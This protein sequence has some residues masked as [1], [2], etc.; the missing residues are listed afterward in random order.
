MVLDNNLAENSMRPIAIG[1][2]NWVHVG[3]AEA[4]PY[5]P[6]IFSIVESTRSAQARQLTLHERHCLIQS[7]NKMSKP[8]SANGLLGYGQR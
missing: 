3:S 1:C 6:A 5:V 2:R 4:G 7:K 8:A